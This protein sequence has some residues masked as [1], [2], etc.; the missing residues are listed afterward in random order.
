MVATASRARVQPLGPLTAATVFPNNVPGR[1]ISKANIAVGNGQAVLNLLSPFF[2]PLLSLLCQMVNS[3]GV[4]VFDN[5]LFPNG[6]RK[7]AI[8][9]QFGL[10]IQNSA[11]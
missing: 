11:V 8:A 7:R 9:L 2:P 1:P 4:G 5:L 6:S 3:E 10:D